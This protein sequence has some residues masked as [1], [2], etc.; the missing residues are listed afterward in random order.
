MHFTSAGNGAASSNDPSDEQSEESS[1][2]PATSTAR[3]LGTNIDF[4]ASAII[5]DS[6]QRQRAVAAAACLFGMN[7]M[8]PNSGPMST[9][10]GGFP[11][12]F[13]MIPGLNPWPSL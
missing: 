1:T 5:A 11:P 9:R 4:S 8:P 6:L 3:N 2:P 13:P 7:L 12:V 10:A